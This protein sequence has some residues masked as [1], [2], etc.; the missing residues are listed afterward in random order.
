[1]TVVE[2]VRFL[3]DTVGLI[4]ESDRARLV[5]FI[6]ANPEAGDVVPDTGGV[7]KLRWAL[8]GRGKRGGARMIY[9]FYNE[10]LPVFLLAM[11][12]KNEK[13]NLTREERNAM[14]KLLPA[15]TSGYPKG[16]GRK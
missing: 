15:L 9:F 13:A 12:G 10:S 2:T 3:K 5:E 7:R 4:D 11:Y 1:M 16:R 6:G 14:T 8:A